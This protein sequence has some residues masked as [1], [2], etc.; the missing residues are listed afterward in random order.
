MAT[1]LELWDFG[2]PFEVRDGDH[3]VYVGLQGTKNL[4]SSPLG[5]SA[6]G[7]N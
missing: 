4:L 1:H 7:G 6:A 5:A 2:K 3:G